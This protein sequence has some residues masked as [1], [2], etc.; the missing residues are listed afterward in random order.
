MLRSG[1]IW[2]RLGARYTCPLQH[3][4]PGRST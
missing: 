2:R 3:K 1:A 4:A